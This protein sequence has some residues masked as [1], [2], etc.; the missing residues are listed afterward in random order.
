[1]AKLTFVDGVLPN[2]PF[3]GSSI[4]FGVGPRASSKKP[5]SPEAVEPDS[6]SGMTEAER[7]E[8]LTMMRKTDEAQANLRGELLAMDKPK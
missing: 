7:R 4:I 5:S 8:Q 3:S 1:M 6:Y 2:S